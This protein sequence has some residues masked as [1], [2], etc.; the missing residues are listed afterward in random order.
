[1]FI[2]DYHLQTLLYPQYESLYLALSFLTVIYLTLEKYIT[3]A[4]TRLAFQRPKTGAAD[5]ANG[6]RKP[7]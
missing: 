4:C 7:I 6:P 2:V 1:M 5:Y 3:A